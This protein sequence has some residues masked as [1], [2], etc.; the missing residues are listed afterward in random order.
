LRACCSIQVE[1]LDPAA[2]DR[3]EREHVQAAQPDGVYGEEV[4]GEDRLAVGSKEAAPGLRIAPRRRWQPS[5]DQDVADGARRD[6]DAQ[7]AQLAGDP[8]IAPTRVLAREPQDQLAYLTTD[9][10]PT[11]AAVRVGPAASDKPAMP[12]QERLRPHRERRPGAAR[13]HPA[14]RRQQDA[15]VRLE[16]RAADLAAKDRQLVAEHENLELLGSIPA[17]EEHDELQQTADDD[18]QG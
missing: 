1:V 7:L 3:D 10:R 5:L 13:K 16:A 9:R 15:V 11:G 12:G 2:A 18:V 4:A 17:A 6:A 14:E 8:Q